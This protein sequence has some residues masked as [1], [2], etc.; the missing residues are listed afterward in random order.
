[1]SDEQQIA[2][3]RHAE[4]EWSET[5]RHTSFTDM[6]LTEEGRRKARLLGERLEGERFTRVLT[7]P[8]Q[9]ATETC[10]L[11]GFGETAEVR[12]DLCEWDYGDYEGRTTVGIRD[13][14]PGW[15]LWYDGAP[16][17]ESPEQVAERVDRLVDEFR[18]LCEQGCDVLVFGHG[19]LSQALAIRWVGLPIADGRLIRLGAGGLSRLTWKREYRVIDTLND[20]SHLRE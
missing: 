4:T 10:R 11:A 7:S 1:M 17:G 13:Q 15:T 18:E 2:L 5:G 19:H 12:T 14:D 9:R 20:R 6:P 8:L 3:V 16:G